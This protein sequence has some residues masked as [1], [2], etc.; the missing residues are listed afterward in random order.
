MNILAVDTSSENLSLYIR[1]GKDK[2]IDF[3]R[4]IKFGASQLI[5]FIDKNLKRVKLSL[6]DIDTFVIGAG[7]G[8]FTGL[9]IS[10]SLVKAFMLATKKPAIVLSSFYACAYPFKN[11]AEKVAVISDARRGLIYLASFNCQGGNLIKE[12]KAKLVT[13]DQLGKVSG[14]YLFITYDSN[15]RQQIL[16]LNSQLSIYPQD[17]YPRAKYLMPL[18]EIYYNK[19]KFTSLDKLSPLYLH[20]KAP[21]VRRKK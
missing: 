6:S 5:S 2:E 16:G 9:R 15:L 19:G 1:K 18:A 14:D 3:N 17:V 12:V 7:P 8:S 21:Q 10:F 4:R 13:L 11:K 20:S